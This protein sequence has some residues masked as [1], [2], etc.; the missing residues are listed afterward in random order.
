MSQNLRIESG[1]LS[2]YRAAVRMM[3]EAEFCAASTD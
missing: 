3:K 2:M 1:A